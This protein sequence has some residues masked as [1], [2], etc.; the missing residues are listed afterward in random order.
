MK[1]V[2]DKDEKKGLLRAFSKQEIFI[3]TQSLSTKDVNW[4]ISR[5]KNI[6]QIMNSS[7]IFGY[8]LANPDPIL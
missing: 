3:L 4:D 7:L 8:R 1:Q 5:L 2:K 6:F